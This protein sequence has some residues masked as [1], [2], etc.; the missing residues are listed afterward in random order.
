MTT[1][2]GVRFREVGK[3][4]YFDPGSLDINA[5]DHVIVDTVRGMECGTVMLGK[6][7]VPDEEI[8][9]P[10]KVVRRIATPMNGK[11]PIKLS[12]GYKTF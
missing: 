5:G 4:Y 1:V 11:K 10:L 8:V 9:P 2:V 6:R 3:I 7:E 12:C